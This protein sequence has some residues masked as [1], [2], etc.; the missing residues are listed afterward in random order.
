M[1]TCPWH[2]TYKV[3]YTLKGDVGCGKRV[4][5]VESAS[6]GMAKQQVIEENGGPLNCMPWSAVPID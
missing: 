3:T 1:A 5:L 6:A 2:H 4:V